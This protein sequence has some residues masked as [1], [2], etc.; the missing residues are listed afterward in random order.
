MGDSGSQFIGFMIASLAIL[1]TSAKSNPISPYFVPIL[2]AP[3]IFDVVLT[4]IYRAAR[5]E[6]VLR[7]HREHLYQIGTKLG[8]SHTQ[9][10]MVYFAL[11]GLSGAVAFFVDVSLTMTA[12][13]LVLALFL[14][15]CILAVLT[16]RAGLRAGVVEPL[17][18][19]QSQTEG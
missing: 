8:A 15:L 4:L 17:R 14:V 9:V 13:L 7:A 5:K 18:Q 11:T 10:S 6:N 19:A 16:Y 3:F 12:L 2:F 1:A